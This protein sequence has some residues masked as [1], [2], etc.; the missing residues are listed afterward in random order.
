MSIVYALEN[1]NKSFDTITGWLR[2][3]MARTEQAFQSFQVERVLRKILAEKFA[4]PNDTP[5]SEPPEYVHRPEGP[6]PRT[7]QLPGKGPSSAQ[8]I[9][10]K[11]D[12]MPPTPISIEAEALKVNPQAI[13]SRQGCR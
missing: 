13:P 6:D 3:F 8:Y 11:D 10:I 12:F 2:K 5:R 4:M 9:A 7:H 1:I